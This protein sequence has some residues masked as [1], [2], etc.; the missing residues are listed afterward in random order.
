L[1][2]RISFQFFFHRMGF[3]GDILSLELKYI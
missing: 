2:V 1:S 3:R